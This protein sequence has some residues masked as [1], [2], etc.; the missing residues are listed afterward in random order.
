MEIKVQ[1][2]E[3]LKKVGLGVNVAA[4]KPS[5]LPIL[6]NLLFE[7]QKDGKVKIVAT[8]ME[9]GISTLLS[10]EISQGGS[11]TVPARKFFDIIKELPE[12]S[13]EISVTKNN[14]ISIKAGKSHFKIM[15]LDKEEYPKLPEFNLENA[16]E[17][18]QAVIKESLSLTSF[19]IS[20]D[21]TRYVLNGILLS[22]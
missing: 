14:T 15:G 17:I 4:A 7:T 6:N 8:D 13:V 16:I 2:S 20:H 5:T 9:V 3:L 18:E 21:E 22:L 11:I 12:G 10:V 1:K 19:A